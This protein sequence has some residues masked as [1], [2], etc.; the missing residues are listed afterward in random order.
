MDHLVRT[1]NLSLDQDSELIEKANQDFVKSIVDSLVWRF[2]FT[3]LISSFRMCDARQENYK[4]F[5]LKREIF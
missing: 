4:S 2:E 1:I 3:L 5:V